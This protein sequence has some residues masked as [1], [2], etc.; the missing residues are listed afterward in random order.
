MIDNKKITKKVQESLTFASY[1]KSPLH[2]DTYLKENIFLADIN[3]ERIE[4]N[5]TYKKHM[6]SL[7]VLALITAGKDMIVV[8]RSSPQFNF[9][10]IVREDTCGHPQFSIF[11]FRMLQDA[12][13]L[14]DG[15]GS[16]SYCLHYK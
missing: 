9:Y 11:Y 12:S 2:Y 10:K 8:P 5:E 13:G 7:N 15:M 16:F 14:W 4:K 3:N 6:T 1:W